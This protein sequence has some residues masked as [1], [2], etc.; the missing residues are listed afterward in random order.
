MRRGTADHPKVY[1]LMAELGCELPYAIGMLELLWHW[2]AKYAPQGDVG[3]W[4][5]LDIARATGATLQP[6]RGRAGAR[7][8]QI[9]AGLTAA[10]WL[11]SAPDPWRLVIHDVQVHADNTWRQHLEDLGLTWWD[12]TPARSAKRGRPGKAGNVDSQPV[13][14]IKIPPPSLPF[15]LLA[16]AAEEFS[17]SREAVTAM[18]P[19]TD[20]RTMRRILGAVLETAPG[21]TDEEIARA[22]PA[23]TFRAQ[24]SGAGY[25]KTLPEVVSNMRAAA[26]RAEEKATRRWEAEELPDILRML[27]DPNVTQAE[28]EICEETLAYH[29]VSR[30]AGKAKQ[31]RAS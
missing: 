30:P 3:R 18:Y 10:G 11:D 7:A 23:A 20:E 22:V 17:L 31:A 8:G 27:E 15:P 19:A 24:R 9:V 29:K 2:S 12:G 28:R 1:A 4:P 14:G 5:D 6:R 16:A 25:T 26:H 21:A 13:S